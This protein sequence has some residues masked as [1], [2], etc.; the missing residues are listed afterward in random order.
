MVEHGLRDDDSLVRQTAAAELGQMKCVASIPA[1]K[2]ALDDP[3]GEVVFSAAKA[4]WDWGI[5]AAKKCCRR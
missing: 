1:L 2:A 5:I 3:S 4:L